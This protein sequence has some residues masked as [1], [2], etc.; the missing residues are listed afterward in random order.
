MRN[1]NFSQIIVK[2]LTILLLLNKLQEFIFSEIFIWFSPTKTEDL[3]NQ[4]NFSITDYDESP[5]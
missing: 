5:V 2:F 4:K 1:C 3:V